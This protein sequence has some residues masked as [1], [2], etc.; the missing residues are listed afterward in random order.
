MKKRFFEID[1]ARGA[2]VVLMIL[3]H[4]AFDANYFGVYRL[5]LGWVFWFLFPR[6]IASVFIILAGVSLTLNYNSSKKGFEKRI[7]RRGMVIFSFGLVITAITYLFLPKGAIF[8]GILHFMGI[9]AIMAIP[10]VKMRKKALLLGIASLLAGGYLQT[11][12]VNFP[13]LLWLGLMPENFYTFDYFPIFPWFGLMLSGI[14]AGNKFYAGG[15]RKFKI[16]ER[17]ARLLTFL[18]RNSLVIYLVHQP[19]LAALIL[20]LR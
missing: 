4:A 17:P 18:G 12:D 9:S 15:R 10:L 7:F 11:V 14:F 20:V 19:L 5:D 3:F 8:F 1:A 6:L 13:W 2:A 16:K